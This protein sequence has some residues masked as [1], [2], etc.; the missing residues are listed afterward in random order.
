[1][2]QIVICFFL[3]GGFTTSA[4]GY[5]SRGRAE[6]TVFRSLDGLD[7]SR[8]KT[9]SAG[10]I[11]GNQFSKRECQNELNNIHNAGNYLRGLQRSGALE[12]PSKMPA[13]IS[14]ANNEIESQLQS[15]LGKIK[16]KIASKTRPVSGEK[17]YD[18]YLA[19]KKYEKDFE[20]YPQLE[21]QFK[22]K[23]EAAYHTFKNQF[24]FGMQANSRSGSNYTPNV[25]ESTT[26]TIFYITTHPH[27]RDPTL[28]DNYNKLLAELIKKSQCDPEKIKSC[29]ES[30]LKQVE[31][32]SK[33]GLRNYCNKA[34]R[35][36]QV[37]CSNP[38]KSCGDFAFAKDITN[39]F[40]K[41]TPAI[42][43]MFA[44]LRGIQG[45]AEDACKL[46]ALGSVVTPLGNL[47]I[48]S[49]NQAIEGCKAT[50][51][52]RIAKFKNDFK[53]CYKIQEGETIREII[54]KAVGEGFEE[55]DPKAPCKDEIAKVAEAY[56]ELSI[57]SSYNLSEESDHEEIVACRGEIGRYA[58]GA[59]AMG[60]A[61]QL[62]VNMCYG[63]INQ[64]TAQAAPPPGPGNIPYTP[65]TGVAGFAGTTPHR[66]FP[67]L[68]PMAEEGMPETPGVD[69]D[70]DFLPPGPE[71]PKGGNVG[72]VPS[73]GG[74]GSGGSAGLGGAGG[75]SSGGS[76]GND[77][78]ARAMA[79]LGPGGEGDFAFQAG[80]EE[81]EGE[82]N[83]SWAE[84]DDF[85]PQIEKD[86]KKAEDLKKLPDKYLTDEERDLL[87]AF[88]PPGK[89]ENIFDFH[90]FMFHWFCRNYGCSGYFKAMGIPEDMR[91]KIL[92]PK[93][94]IKKEE[95]E[96]LIKK[97]KG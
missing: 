78:G 32:D 38:N 53:R 65:P 18:E 45:R 70:G 88:S 16:A 35:E 24:L 97:T 55:E 7:L 59:G 77:K 4:Y 14:S 66:E 93:K 40:S 1:M 63:E 36:G 69:D 71:P 43:K 23:I 61:E 91:R 90:S 11:K 73:G 25:D 80:M 21:R 96:K 39:A 60:P 94:F 34:L 29:H 6:T 27:L 48:D 10:L 8:Q 15:C 58:P 42:F 33:S 82:D 41:S 76:G 52:S 64:P 85:G 20:R 9:H 75:G 81:G 87:R 13:A 44:Q 37:C 57:E 83:N 17:W 74:G 79:G 30:L 51:D 95:A 54:K 47:Q 92:E 26:E 12:N 22:G 72:F 84:G 19:E 5:D 2:L 86:R 49:C 3:T 89:H 62:A 50:C 28:V 56:K 46:S 31:G 68:S 67:G